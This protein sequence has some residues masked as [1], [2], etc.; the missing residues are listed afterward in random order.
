MTVLSPPRPAVIDRAL[1]DARAWCAG[2]RIDDRPALVH[3]VRVAVIIGDHVPA[4]PREVIAAALLHDAPDLAPATV[5]VY[6]V[7]TA[8]YGPEVARIIAALQ[9]EHSAL[10]E[11]D[12]PICVDDQPVL[13]ASTADKIVALTSLLRRARITG[14]VTGFFARRPVL[15]GLLPHFRAFQRAAHLRVPA[16]MSAHLHA[17]LARLEQVT[18]AIGASGPR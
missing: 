7:L 12:P 4:P 3:A 2:H 9:A 15:C 14:D 10:D 5:D 8:G 13:L 18:A 1:R 11:P 17:V 6:Q 16:S